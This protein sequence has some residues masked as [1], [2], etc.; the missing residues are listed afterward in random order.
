MLGNIAP[1]LENN[2]SLVG[3]ISTL[4]D[5]GLNQVNGWVKASFHQRFFDTRR[6]DVDHL[7]V[8]VVDAQGLVVVLPRCL[9]YTSDAADE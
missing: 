5:G 2:A 7:R 8:E 3:Q 6:N 9:L 1:V 4:A